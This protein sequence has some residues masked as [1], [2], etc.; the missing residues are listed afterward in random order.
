[1]TGLLALV[2]LGL[3]LMGSYLQILSPEEADLE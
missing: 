1:V 2:H 3:S